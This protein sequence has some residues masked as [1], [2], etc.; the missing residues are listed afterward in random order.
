MF[1][2]F[3]A[4]QR[5]AH[6]NRQNLS[7]ALPIR[8]QCLTT[9]SD[10]SSSSTWLAWYSKRLETHP[11]TT[12]GVTSG[13]ISGTGDTICQYVASPEDPWDLLRTARFVAMG[14]FWVAPMTHVWYDALSTR[15]IPGGRSRSK[16]FQRL[17]LDQFG[18]APLFVPSF[19]AGLWILEGRDNIWEN[20]VSIAPS[21]I[22]ANWALW[23]PAQLINFSMIPLNYQVLFGNVVA[24]VWNIYLSWINASTAS[25]SEAA[26]TSSEHPTSYSSSEGGLQ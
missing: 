23:I 7:A 20:L 24:L 11:L 10:S 2:R 19:M 21:V 13:L 18:F 15:I 8:R 3:L 25:P 9:S 14:V 4:A 12:K 1:S 26:S 6:H 17:L 16:V 5:A 22:E